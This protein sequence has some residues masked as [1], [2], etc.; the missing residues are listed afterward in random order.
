MMDRPS[1]S[2]SLARAYTESAPSPLITDILEA[3]GRIFALPPTSPRSLRIQE[4]RLRRRGDGYPQPVDKTRKELKNCRRRDQFY[5]LGIGVRIL[6]LRKK[7]VVDLGCRAMQPVG[8]SES[9]L[10]RVAER[11]IFIVRLHRLDLLLARS[12]L[13]GR[14][15]VRLDRIFGAE[16]DRNPRRN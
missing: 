15:R 13:L 7:L 9:Q 11:A 4:L 16:Q 5:D 1:R 3:S 6:Q 12:L 8:T 10:F 2:S 14:K